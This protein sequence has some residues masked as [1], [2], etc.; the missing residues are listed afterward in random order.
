MMHQPAH[1]DTEHPAGQIRPN[2]MQVSREAVNSR[3][4]ELFGI[5]VKKA[6]QIARAAIK[7]ENRKSAR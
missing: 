1:K 6:D 7:R 4:H 5:K 3:R 2:E